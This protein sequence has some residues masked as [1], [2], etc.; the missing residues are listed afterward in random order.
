MG[1]KFK[2][3]IALSVFGLAVAS[4]KSYSVTLSEPALLGT[5]QLAPGDY[6]VEV[7][8]QKAVITSGKIRTECPVKVESADNKYN[9]TA[10]RFSNGDGKMHIQEIHIG[11]TK[12]KLVFNE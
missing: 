12:T 10:V 9:S 11:G 5:T 1:M 8:D 4:A 7:N 2:L 3:L 6:K